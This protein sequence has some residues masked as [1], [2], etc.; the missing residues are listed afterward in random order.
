MK[1]FFLSSVLLTSVCL[2]GV[3]CLNTEETGISSN[4][5]IITFSLANAGQ[6]TFGTQT[7]TIDNTNNVI[8]NVDSLPYQSQL[9]SVIVTVVGESLS[10][11][12]IND[13]IVFTTN[14]TLNLSELVTIQT[15]AQDGE[16]VK[17]YSLDLR[18]HQIDPYLYIWTGINSQVY[19]GA[20]TVE[21]LVHFNGELLL[22]VDEGNDH[23]ALHRSADG[24]TWTASTVSG[25][26]AAFDIRYIV[27]FSEQLIALHNNVAYFSTD[28]QTWN[29]RPASGVAVSNLLFAMNDKLYALGGSGS[30][31]FVAEAD[32]TL[33][34]TGIGELPSPFPITGAGIYVGTSQSGV[35]R[36]F[37]VG[38]K[39]GN[40]ALL[41][42]VWSSENGRYWANLA[43][44]GVPFTPREGVAVVQYDSLLMLFGGR[45][46]SGLA[47]D[48]Q[49]VSRSFGI[50]WTLP[51]DKETISSLFVP[52][53][54]A[55]IA[56]N[57]EKYTIFIVSGRTSVG[58]IKDVWRGRKNEKLFLLK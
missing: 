51:Q 33:A 38:G 40:G 14:D 43:S 42:T 25:L 9:D 17:T 52:R 1:N 27:K 2:T 50:T 20:V 49:W 47:N 18:I 57:E 35:P 56:V 29:T 10:A 16:T 45:D 3:S 55:Q 39:D 32:S 22:F 5:N 21:K 24:I 11:V 28:G 44:N 53:Y 30:A 34:F 37:V 41:N 54:D 13:S 6:G 58:F 23:I 4:P 46:A 48:I 19:T 8:Y 31:L 15:V 12:I 36:V 26:P 7:F